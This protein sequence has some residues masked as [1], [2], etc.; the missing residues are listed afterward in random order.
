MT[1]PRRSVQDLE[2][3][4]LHPVIQDTAERGLPIPQMPDAWISRALVNPYYDDEIRAVRTVCVHSK[5]QM[6]HQSYG[7]AETAFSLFFKDGDLYLMPHDRTTAPIGPIGM[8]VAVPGRNMFAVHGLLNQGSGFLYNQPVNFYLGYSPEAN[9]YK[10]NTPPTAMQTCNWV[11]AKKTQKLECLPL[12]WFFTNANNPCGIP[13]LGLFA[14]AT[15]ENFESSDAVDQLDWASDL[16]KSADAASASLISALQNAK[17]TKAFH[18]AIVDNLKNRPE[19]WQG[20]SEQPGQIITGLGPADKGTGEP[21]W[22]KR[23]KMTGF[24][25]Q[26]SKHDPSE[27]LGDAAMPLRVYYDW[28]S[29]GLQDAHML[30][31][32]SL[33]QHEWF[34]ADHMDIFLDAKGNDTF[35][36]FQDGHTKFEGH[37]ATGI[38]K[39]NWAAMDHGAAKASLRNNPLICPGEV[40]NI[41]TLPND[42]RHFWVWYTPENKGVLFMEIPQKADVLLVLT[43]YYTYDMDP[44]AFPKDWWMEPPKTQSS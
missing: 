26:T 19:F 16:C 9:G 31:H 6:F 4:N 29:T 38:V 11:W 8:D 1:D 30:T 2:N 14:L 41:T 39:Y 27:G 25:Y 34:D 13:Y 32:L 3:Y 28:P 20:S 36:T 42:D 7:V 10:G 40:L 35:V 44:P 17:D 22:D 37:D 23:I 21:E 33:N 43:D 24:T 12:R 15:F 5:A 18:G